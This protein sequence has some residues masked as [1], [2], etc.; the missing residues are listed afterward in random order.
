M[1]QMQI[2]NLIENE[3]DDFSLASLQKKLNLAEMENVDAYSSPSGCHA[4][5]RRN[6]DRDEKMQALKNIYSEYRLDRGS[7]PKF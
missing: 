5:Q 7:A 2:N 4:N 3:D 1:L 6:R